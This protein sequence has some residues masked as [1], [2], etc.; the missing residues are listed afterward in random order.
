M[1]ENNLYPRISTQVMNKF[2]ALKNLPRTHPGL[3]WILVFTLLSRI[4]VYLIGQPWNQEVIEDKILD[5]DAEL[6]LLPAL[7]E[8]LARKSEKVLA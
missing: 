8:E 1:T 7:R 2:D 4:A 3:F 6:D 5:G